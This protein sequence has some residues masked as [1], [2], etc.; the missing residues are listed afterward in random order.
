MPSMIRWGKLEC[1][2]G[3]PHLGPRLA[4]HAPR[5]YRFFACDRNF[6]ASLSHQP[7]PKLRTLRLWRLR[8]SP[9]RKQ[10]QQITVLKIIHVDRGI[11]LGDHVYS[12]RFLSEC[13]TRL[14]E[15]RLRHSLTLD[16][17]GVA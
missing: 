10:R 9:N 14:A 16:V 11:F 17:G 2:H 15:A 3:L 5:S 13:A 1:P 8:Q 4:K 7:R 12:R 6:L